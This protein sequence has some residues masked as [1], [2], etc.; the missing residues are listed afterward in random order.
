MKYWVY[1]I[2]WRTRA[3]SIVAEVGSEAEG[4]LAIAKMFAEA[5]PARRDELAKY[6]T[7]AV[8][9]ASAEM[10]EFSEK[11]VRKGERVALCAAGTT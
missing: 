9:L 1:L 8:T 6:F 2:D 4:D 10:E 11:F 3:V 7:A 5:D